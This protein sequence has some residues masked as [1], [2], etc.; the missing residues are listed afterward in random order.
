M[1][2]TQF[3]PRGK[4]ILVVD[5]EKRMVEFVRMN[6]ELEGY[7]VATANNGLEALQSLRDNLPARQ[8]A[9]P[10]TAGRDDATDGWV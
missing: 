6:L 10:D 8:S 2:V 1:E 5:D 4:L 7:R 3:S 9:R